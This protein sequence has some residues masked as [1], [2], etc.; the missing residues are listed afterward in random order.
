MPAGKAVIIILVESQLKS[1]TIIQIFTD[2]VELGLVESV[3]D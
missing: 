2:G 3:D 1:F